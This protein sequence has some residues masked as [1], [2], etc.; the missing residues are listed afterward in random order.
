MLHGHRDTCFTSLP[1]MF[2]RRR[3][4][5]LALPTIYR[6][7][8]SIPEMQLNPDGTVILFLFTTAATAWPLIRDGTDNRASQVEEEKLLLVPPREMY[9]M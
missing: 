9:S 4:C 2:Y 8:Q 5:S 1:V 3:L 7:D 6:P